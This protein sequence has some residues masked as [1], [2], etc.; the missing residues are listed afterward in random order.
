MKGNY[1][2]IFSGSRLAAAAGGLGRDDRLLN[3][4]LWGEIIA[5]SDGHK[6]RSCAEAVR[7]GGFSEEFYSIRS[8]H[9]GVRLGRVLVP[10]DGPRGRENPRALPDL[11]SPTLHWLDTCHTWP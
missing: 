4:L 9:G 11:C 7:E 2:K 5:F 3:I 6:L 1:N 8:R 10:E